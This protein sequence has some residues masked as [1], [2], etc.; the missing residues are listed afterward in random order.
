MLFT[1]PSRRFQRVSH[2][3]GGHCR[4]K[5][6]LPLEENVLRPSSTEWPIWDD[7]SLQNP[8][9]C[10][11]VVPLRHEIALAG[12]LEKQRARRAPPIRRFDLRASAIVLRALVTRVGRAFSG[13]RVLPSERRSN[14]Y[15]EDGMGSGAKIFMRDGGEEILRTVCGRAFGGKPK[16]D[17]SSLSNPAGR[18]SE[19]L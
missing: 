7:D 13:A 4:D 16:K 14:S 2:G 3:A 5:T 11:E 6:V 17:Q 18:M 12:Y 8:R 9:P 19:I 15:R 10:D 1:I